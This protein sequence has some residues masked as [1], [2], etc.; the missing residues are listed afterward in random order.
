MGTRVPKVD[1]PERVTGSAIF[2]ADFSLP[3]MLHGKVL[4]SPHPHA[5]IKGIDYTKA[6][7]LEGVKAVVTCKDLP[8]K[9]T[10]VGTAGGELLIDIAHLRQTVV[11]H[12]KALY[13]GHP[14]AAVCAT[15]PY[16]AQDA[17]DL[18]EVDYEPLPVVENALDAM[19]PDSPLLHDDLYTETLGA[20]PDRPSNIAKHIELGRGDV[21]AGLREAD[22]T[23]ENTYTT[24]MVHQGYIEPQACVA[25]VRPDGRATVWTTTQGSFNIKKQLVIML[26]VPHSQLRVV[27]LE[28]GGGFGGKIYVILEPLA[29]LLA[30]KSGRPVKMV[31]TREEVFKATGPGSPTVIKIKTGARRDG[32]L[33]AISAELIYDAGAFPGSPVS[34]AS[35]VGVTPYKVANLK[36]DG[37]DVLTN[38]P[39]VQAYRAPGGTP[40]AFAVES[41]MNMLA[42]ALSMDPLEFR[43]KN[44]VEEGD[45]DAA[46]QPLNRVGL[47]QV[48]ERVAM[49]PAWTGKLE[50]VNRGR[51]MALGYWMGASL[52]SSCNVS[53]NSDGTISLLLG[54]VDVTGVRTTMVQVAAEE[55]GISP[56][57]VSVTVGDTESVGYT[58]LSAGSRTTYSMSAAVREA[59][60]DALAQLKR[61]AATLL[62]VGEDAIEYRE[63]TFR[64][65]V[66][67][68]KSISLADVAKDSIQQGTGPIT[69]KGTNNRLKSAHQFAAHVADV[70]VDPETGKVTLLNYTTFQDVGLA[71][72]PQQVEGQ[73]Q[74]GATQGIAW[75]LT[76]SYYHEKGKLLNASLLDYRI[77]TA[78]DMPMIGTELI[79]VPA[80]DG[81]YGIRGVGEVPI[82]PPP[83]AIADAIYN[84]TG[85]R[86]TSL[87]MTPETVFWTIQAAKKEP[88]TIQA[89]S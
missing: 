17:L 26:Q 28:I 75:A 18:I 7:A 36:V 49:H 19:R 25:E 85:V 57:D 9:E 59:C 67:P 52:A 4:R 21:E 53:V 46:D 42:H 56:E 79:E 35:I 27:P 24:S 5:R 60:L 82:S 10:A 40:V 47:K 84:A 39:R 34:A 48:L 80:S 23:I 41:N 3:S 50:G 66:S 88:A 16:I 78:L 54:S 70:E 65:R 81:P 74:G 2:G 38:K 15:S 45:P 64:S 51:G 30:R 22:V 12:D 61:R 83:G 89:V 76:E 14:V 8:P 13:D 43:M 63:R 87:P 33:T 55:L 44:A 86:V 32:I 29:V 58:D 11:A 71:V 1:A 20:K 72:N 68:D 77:P 37:Y 31:L 69:A 6:L 73:M 62:E